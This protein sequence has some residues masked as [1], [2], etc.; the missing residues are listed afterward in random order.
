MLVG[1]EDHG[2]AVRGT[3][4]AILSGTLIIKTLDYFKN[5]GLDS[6]LAGKTIG[7]LE[8]SRELT[9]KLKAPL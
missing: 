9:H 8:H 3:E 2:S 5:L 7:D 1:G 6:E 4:V